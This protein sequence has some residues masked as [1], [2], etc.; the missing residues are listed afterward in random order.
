MIWVSVLAVLSLATSAATYALLI[1][2]ERTERKAK[3]EALE[4][5]VRGMPPRETPV[6]QLNG[7]TS[8]TKKRKTGVS[9]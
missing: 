1:G 6:R 9:H 4:R 8:G 2:D 5:A 3:R 7:S